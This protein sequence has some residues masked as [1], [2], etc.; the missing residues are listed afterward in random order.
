MKVDS[1]KTKSFQVTSTYR[2]SHVLKYT[3]WFMEGVLN[4]K[5]LP[6]CSIVF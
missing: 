1:S 4:V 5:T 6:K 3:G 2:V